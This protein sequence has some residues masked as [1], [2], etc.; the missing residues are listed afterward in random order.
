MS[1]ISISKNTIITVS[2]A[3]NMLLIGGIV[4]AG[5]NHKSCRDRMKMNNPEAMH[6]MDD[7]DDRGF[8]REEM[9]RGDHECD[10]VHKQRR[11][12][13][14]EFNKTSGIMEIKKQMSDLMMQENFN[15]EE[16]A[17][18]STEL[19][20]KFNEFSQQNIER[21]A[22]M[23]P[24]ERREVAKCDVKPDDMKEDFNDKMNG[25]CRNKDKHQANNKS[26]K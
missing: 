8:N 9:N 18:L 11:E 5:I 16:F 13:M 15:K 22:K 3:L 12:M 10:K 21:I 19:S 20:K 17:K 14:G 7:R 23:S 26:Q 25:E 6:R 2:L 1:N 4:G 24:E